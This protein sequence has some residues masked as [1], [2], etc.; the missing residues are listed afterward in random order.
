MRTTVR[1]P[2]DLLTEAK[3]LAAESH[4]TL[5]RLIEE[6][7]RERLARRRDLA[8]APPVEL[9]VLRGSRL[10][11]GVDLTSSGALLDLMEGLD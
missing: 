7:L 8:S 11:P 3:K 6:A 2:S 9:P 4:T 5:T 1:L 10:R